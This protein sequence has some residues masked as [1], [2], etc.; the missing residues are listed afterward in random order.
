MSDF[1]LHRLVESKE[2]GIIFFHFKFPNRL[3]FK[4]GACNFFLAWK[5]YEINTLVMFSWF[6]QNFCKKVSF[7][8]E[9]KG[10]PMICWKYY[11]IFVRD[12]KESEQNLYKPLQANEL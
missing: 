10:R 9:K 1:Q 5:M 11:M 3:F 7:R 4:W 6:W 2:K 12:G 8:R